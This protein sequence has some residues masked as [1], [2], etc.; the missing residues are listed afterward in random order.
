MVFTYTGHVPPSDIFLV[1]EYDLVEFWRLTHVGNRNSVS[2]RLRHSPSFAHPALHSDPGP[3]PT[4][5]S[6]F[7]PLYAV[8]SSRYSAAKVLY[9][10]GRQSAISSDIRVARCD[11]ERYSIGKM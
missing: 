4:A 9:L 3:L 8:A 1:A 5:N 10:A 11:I 2:C 6:S 7:I